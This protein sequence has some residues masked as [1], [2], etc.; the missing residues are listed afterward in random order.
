MAIT[1]ITCPDVEQAMTSIT[2]EVEVEHDNSIIYSS[3]MIIIL[4]SYRKI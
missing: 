2:V 3:I 1:M 4:Q